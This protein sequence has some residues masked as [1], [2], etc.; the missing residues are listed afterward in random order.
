MRLVTSGV[1]QIS[2]TSSV[3][4][5]TTIVL[6]RDGDAMTILFPTIAMSVGRSYGSA[7]VRSTRPVRTLKILTLPLNASS[8][9]R[10]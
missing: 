4:K 3:V 1:S 8:A 7:I 10:S 2:V 9:T 6:P 5:S